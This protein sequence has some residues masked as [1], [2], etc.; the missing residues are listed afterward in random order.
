[1]RRSGERDGSENTRPA[2]LAAAPCPERSAAPYPRGRERRKRERSGEK[3]E[4]A[5]RGVRCGNQDDRAD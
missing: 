2:A 3:G 4:K 5:P 1:M